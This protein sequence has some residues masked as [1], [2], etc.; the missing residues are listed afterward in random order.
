MG[1]ASILSACTVSA[2]VLLGTPILLRVGCG[3]AWND[4]L[5]HICVTLNHL[6]VEVSPCS[7]EM[8]GDVNPDPDVTTPSPNP[9]TRDFLLR[10]IS[11]RSGFPDELCM[12]VLSACM[13]RDVLLV[14]SFGARI[15]A[16]DPKGRP[17]GTV[18]QARPGTDKGDPDDLP[19]ITAFAVAGTGDLFVAE[20]GWFLAKF[21]PVSM[22]VTRHQQDPMFRTLIDEAVSTHQ[23]TTPEA[24]VLHGDCLYVSCSAPTP[25]G[26]SREGAVVVFDVSGALLRVVAQGGGFGDAVMG[27]LHRSSLA[28]RRRI[29]GHIRMGGCRWHVAC[30]L[31]TILL[32]H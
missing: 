13:P 25:S 3:A 22:G 18:I 5:N 8:S 11:K 12:R 6:N 21:A 31:T 4:A 27:L 32:H 20:F 23:W 14:V 7:M 1:S 24:C 9:L 28:P 29:V 15:L 30:V 16:F 10:V 2:A 17:L 26:D 19:W